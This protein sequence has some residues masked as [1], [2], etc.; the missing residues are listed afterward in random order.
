MARRTLVLLAALVS[1]GC[2]DWNEQSADFATRAEFRA[3]R[4]AG[5]L[6]ADLLPPS[7]R[8][9]HFKRNRDTTVVDVSFDFAAAEQETMVKPFMS[10]DQIR[11]RLALAEEHGPELP[12]PTMLMRC[13]VGPMEFLH[14]DQPGHARYWTDVDRQR[15]QHACTNG[16]SRPKTAA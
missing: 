6:P 16:A 13:G 15:R 10:F 14:V 12:L 3:S 11:L 7:A 8:N 1:G 5:A 4:Y 9:I 2:T